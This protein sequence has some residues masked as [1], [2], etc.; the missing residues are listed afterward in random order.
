MMRRMRAWFPAGDGERGAL[1]P[2]VAIVALAALIMIGLAFD[3]GKKAQATQMAVAVADEAARAGG[4]AVSF[5]GVIGEGPAAVDVAA[6]VAAAQS[7][8][9]AAG[10]AGDV[11]VV[12][13]GRELV[14]TTTIQIPTVFL[15]LIGIDS[16]TVTGTGQAD[17]VGS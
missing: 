15:G 1:S 3:G 16:M 2:M 9:N 7:Y 13:G 4:Q 8:L 12:G 5:E 17:L 11:S 14:V 10:V 6:A